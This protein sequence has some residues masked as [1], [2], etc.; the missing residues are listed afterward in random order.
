MP[1][2]RDRREPGA[3]TPSEAVQ[4]YLRRRQQDATEESVKSYHYRLK[5]FVEFCEDEGIERVDALRPFDLDEFY[6]IRAA[7]I[8]PATLKGQ[9]HT[10]RGF[11]RYLAQIDAVDGDLPESVQIPR[12]SEEEEVSE[13]VWDYEIA[14]TALD[15]WA[16]HDPGCRDHAL[17]E[18]LLITGAR[19]GGIRALDVQDVY[20]DEQYV[21]FV[22]RP[23]TGT[24]LKKGKDGERPVAIPDRTVE[25]L[26][27][28]LA[29]RPDTHDEHGRAPLLPSQRGRPTKSAI[30]GWVY[31]ATVPCIWT[32]CPHERE[33]ETCDW[34]L[35][36]SASHCP[37]SVSPHPVRSGSM[38]YQRDLGFPKEVVAERCNASVETVDKHYDA[39]TARQ[40]MEERRRRYVERFDSLSDTNDE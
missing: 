11:L 18:L 26:R 25:V 40:R 10:V 24:R 28:W 27:Q 16:E 19:R 17:M 13:E 8:A 33:R 38:T 32:D 31:A 34:T 22:N 23:D 2:G 37:S 3:F 35:A 6:E 21:D 20:L 29:R 9:M 12:L 36:N 39:A 7:D 15:H 1:E 14:L 4:R 30:A 5:Q